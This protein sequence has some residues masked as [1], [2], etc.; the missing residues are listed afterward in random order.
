MILL[1]VLNEI[2]HVDTA[3]FAVLIIAPIFAIFTIHFL[4]EFR[5]DNYRKQIESR[6]KCK[7]CN[8]QVAGIKIHLVLTNEYCPYCKATLP[9]LLG[10][11]TTNTTGIDEPLHG[12]TSQ[13]VR[14]KIGGK[15]CSHF[16]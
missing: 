3:G 9:Q 4:Y 2:L 5:L 16:L 14:T 13:V 6:L 12:L 15:S 11:D 10:L 8:R 1:T 7:C